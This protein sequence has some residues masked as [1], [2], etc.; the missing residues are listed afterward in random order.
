[1][2]KVNKKKAL[3]IGGVIA[4]IL[5]IAFIILF[6]FPAFNNN[7]FGDR[8]DGIDEHKISSSSINEMKDELQNQEGVEDVSFSDEGGRVLSFIITVDPN[9]D[10]ETAKGYS[11][12]VLD[13]ISKKN[14]DYYDIQFSITT[15]EDSDVYPV[16]GY[17]SKNEKEM[18]F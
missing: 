7:K 11:S 6:V 8:L 3:I 18:V 10:V 1:M 12:I 14:K 17:K 9:L 5:F 13:G 16:I 2:S 4:I 15:E